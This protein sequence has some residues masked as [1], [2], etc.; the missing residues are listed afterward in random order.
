ME[1]NFW[2]FYGIMIERINFFGFL[3]IYFKIIVYFDVVERGGYL[4]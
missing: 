2:L 3:V 1:F 4:L